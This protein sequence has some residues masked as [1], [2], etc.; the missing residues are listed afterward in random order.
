[1]SIEQ[2]HAA[3]MKLAGLLRGY[4]AEVTS[5]DRKS[6]DAAVASMPRGSEVYI[7]SLPSDDEDR[8]VSVARELQRAGLTPVPHIVAR[9]IGSRGD[10]DV[11]I[12]RF[13]REAGVDRA[14]V[15]GGDRAQPAGDF[16]SSLQLLETGLLGVHGIRIIAL[17][18]Y[19][20]GHPRIPD[21]V[22]EDARRA[23]MQRAAEDGLRV[24]FISQFCFESAPILASA[25]RLRAEGITAPLRIGVAGP[26]SRTSLLKYAMICG[27]G[28]SVRALSE[29]PGAGAKLREEHQEELLGEIAAAQALDAAPVFDGVH[30]FTFASLAATVKFVQEHTHPPATV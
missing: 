11:L 13:S 7:A 27:V 22:L 29:R 28:A 14:L 18:W 8:R 20:E 23:K 17:A 30:F 9:N 3:G 4:S 5:A 19:P 2:P 10:L 24:K 1:M 21:A 15:L 16:H 26:A 6:I 25:Q 12:R